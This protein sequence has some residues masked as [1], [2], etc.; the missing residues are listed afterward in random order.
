MKKLL[1]SFT[2]V[3]VLSVLTRLFSMICKIA[4]TRKLSSYDLGVYQSGMSV[5]A[6]MLTI[7][8]SGFPLTV[9]RAFARNER[10][11]RT[12][13][14]SSVICFALSFLLCVI[15]YFSSGVLG[16]LFDDEKSLEALKILLPALIVSSLYCQLRGALWG[17]ERFFAFSFAEFFEEIIYV[18]TVVLLLVFKPELSL[19]IPCIAISISSAFSCIYAFIAY[20]AFGGKI[21][22]ATKKDYSESFS[23][24]FP[25]ISV[26][27]LA[28]VTSAI[29]TLTLPKRIMLSGKTLEESLSLIGLFSGVI[30]PLL[31]APSA[32]IGSL[33]LVLLPKI[34]KADGKNKA[35]AIYAV[36][37]ASL[38][39]AVVAALFFSLSKE[40][41]FGV[42]GKDNA[43]QLLK[44][45]TLAIFPMSI[46][47][48]SASILNSLGFEKETLKSFLT[49]AVLSVITAIT[50]SPYISI[51]AQIVAMTLQA[52]SSSAMNLYHMSKALEIPLK[53]LLKSLSLN[54]LS[55]FLAIVAYSAE[56]LFI[57]SHFI[58]S[59]IIVSLITMLTLAI[60][61]TPFILKLSKKRLSSEEKTIDERK[62]KA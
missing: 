9:S 32:I 36:S 35:T 27:I 48:I 11:E 37:F 62:K 45:S 7:V 4:L 21:Y 56:K 40:L 38:L 19:Y 49:G 44:I 55:I 42:F 34:A 16:N 20:F 43:S 31:F 26:R 3:T 58:I 25:I 14:A 23:S 51:Y 46:N 22:F 8:S 15:I 6:I 12:L 29:M 54:L 60:M 5:F 33:C 39:S 47:Q 1:K 52:I 61:F 30:N 24:S 17:K 28:S 2:T 57:N 41:T 13:F 59:I 10:G 53:S 50:L 18:L